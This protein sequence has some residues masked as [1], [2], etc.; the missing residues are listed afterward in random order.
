M[1]A[2]MRQADGPG[3][4]S[5]SLCAAPPASPSTARS[6]VLR[7]GRGR[8]GQSSTAGLA[9]ES[10]TRRARAG[11]AARSRST[12]RL[13]SARSPAGR[14]C[15]TRPAGSGRSGAPLPRRRGRRGRCCG[16][17]STRRSVAPM[18]ITNVVGHTVTAPHGSTSG[19]GESPP[20][21]SNS[22]RSLRWARRKRDVEQGRSSYT[23]YHSHPRGFRSWWA[24]ASARP[25]SG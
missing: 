14:C 21:S 16:W 9:G 3:P 24:P 2:C 20:C 25:D 11:A 22:A 4:V 8:R 15:A 10:A 17:T 7:P 1:A 6:C 19:H 12:A 13:S 23:G 5:P 18:A